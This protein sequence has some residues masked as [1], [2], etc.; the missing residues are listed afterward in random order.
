MKALGECMAR[1]RRAK[2][3]LNPKKCRLI[4]LQG[5]LLGH[6]V[7]KEGLKKDLDKINVIIHMERPTNVT[8]IKSFLGHVGNY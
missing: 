2:L 8:S 4:V 7:C 6:I 5:R 3:A 1:C